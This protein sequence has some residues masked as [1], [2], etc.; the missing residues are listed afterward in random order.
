MTST[1]AQQRSAFAL[2]KIKNLKGDRVSFSKLVPGLPAMILQNGFGQALSFL[3][4]KGTDKNGNIDTKDKHIQA[5]DIMIKWLKE[6]KIIHETDHTKA[7]TELS[8][9]SQDKYL[10]AQEEALAVLEWVK[11]YATAGLF[12]EIK[13]TP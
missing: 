12:K 2:E 1:L 6:Q 13:E 4:A 7:I 11:R 9:M 8:N 3:L 10:R 5:F